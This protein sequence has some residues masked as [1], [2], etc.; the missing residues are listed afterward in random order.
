M[1][2]KEIER[3]NNKINEEHISLSAKK[4]LL[5]VI[6]EF[7]SVDYKNISEKRR[8]EV[9]INFEL[10]HIESKLRYYKSDISTSL[11]NIAK[12]LISNNPQ[13]F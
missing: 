11:K 1:Y 9:E 8:R 12:S 7:F 2:K 3:F 6:E 5:D 10:R 13:Q 4:A